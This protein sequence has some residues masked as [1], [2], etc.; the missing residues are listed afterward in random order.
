MKTNWPI[1]KLGEVA[2]FQN[3]LWKGKR[4]PFI[5]VSVLRNTNFRNGGILD[6]D[7]IAEID[8]EAKQFLERSLKKGD[9]I[10][11]RSGGGPTQP[12]GRVVYFSKEG[13]FSFSNFTTRIRVKDETQL[14]SIYLWRFLH[15][16]YGVGKTEQMQKQTTG[17]RNLNFSEYKEIEIPVPGIE[18]QKRIV[19][20]LKKILANIEEAGRLRQETIEQTKYLW[21]SAI[22]QV[23]QKEDWDIKPLSQIAAINPKKSEVASLDNSTP[24][25]FI[26]MSA[27]DDTSG[28]VTQPLVKNLGEVKNGYTYFGENDVLFAKITPCMENGKIAIAKNLENNIG[29]GSTEFHVIRSNAGTP[30]EWLHAYLRQKSF[31]KEAQSHMTGTA[32]QQRVPK[33]YLENVEIPVPPKEEQKK[34]VEHLDS[35]SEK[36]QTLQKLQEDQLQELE[37]LKQSVLHQAFVG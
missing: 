9:L 26:P 32:G 14:D 30:P 36:V 24:V 3:G 33:N 20:K 1:K 31:R 4:P 35:L 37:R 28:T 7:N 17:I 12:V 29:F 21:E 5:K 11:E 16:F 19:K 6:F 13:E 34:I 10:L 15:Y 2:E 8:V 27:V 22:K 23:Y 18:E 25:T